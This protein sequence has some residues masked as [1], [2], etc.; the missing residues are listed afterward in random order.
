M[1]FIKS[2]QCL[3]CLRTAVVTLWNPKWTSQ[4]YFFAAWLSNKYFSTFWNGIIQISIQRLDLSVCKNSK[5]RSQQQ[6]RSR[7]TVCALGVSCRTCDEA[8]GPNP[9]RAFFT[10]AEGPLSR[11]P[12]KP[13]PLSLL[14]VMLLLLLL[15]L[16]PHKTSCRPAG[17]PEPS[18]KPLTRYATPVSWQRERRRGG[19]R[20]VWGVRGVARLWPGLYV[21]PRRNSLAQLPA[22]FTREV[23]TDARWRRHA[24]AVIRTVLLLPLHAALA[25]HPLSLVV[26]VE[27]QWV[28]REKKKHTQ[29][30]QSYFPYHVYICTTS[31]KF[32]NT[33]WFSFLFMTVNTNSHLRDQNNDEQNI[34]GSML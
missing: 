23:D 15:L 9:T 33:S 7:D 3:R 16:Q 24:A 8:L 6:Q 30:T 25:S 13:P 32:G 31:P 14:W 10:Q 17:L 20:C 2:L 18:P 1:L 4:F 5:T 26:L 34:Y 22:K 11:D 27:Q 21:T 12:I 29:H 28:W 19:G